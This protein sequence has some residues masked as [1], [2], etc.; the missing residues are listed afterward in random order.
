MGKRQVLRLRSQG[1]DAD[2]HRRPALEFVWREAVYVDPSGRNGDA[3]FAGF[4]VASTA[5]RGDRV[6]SQNVTDDVHARVT[7]VAEVL[8]ED[9]KAIPIA[10]SRRVHRRRDAA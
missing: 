5:V 7:L 3:L 2:E 1:A 8:A 9:A 10:V 6:V 4:V